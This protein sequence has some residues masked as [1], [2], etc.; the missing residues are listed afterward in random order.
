[1]SDRTEFT[2]MRSHD[3]RAQN[4]DP[5]RPRFHLAEVQDEAATA[6][7]GRPIFRTVERV[8]ILIPGGLNSPV[9][10]VTDNHRQRWP[11]AYQR[12]KQSNEVAIEGTPID[13]WAVLSRAQVAE[14]KALNVFTVEQCANLNDNVI[15]RIGMGGNAI[16]NA[17]KA[18]LDDA[19]HMKMVTHMT[20]ELDLRDSRITELETAIK[21]QNEVIGQLQA[22]MTM[23]NTEVP[24]MNIPAPV[25]V[26]PLAGMRQPNEATA[27]SLDNLAVRRRP[28]RPAKVEEP[29]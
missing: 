7:Q 5:I 17:A 12:F 10:N 19:E 2:F 14:L 16:R 20:R 26:D 4:H 9:Q 28:G 25:S 8:E 24:G 18:Y 11:E 23:R 29:V 27:S 13:Q 22:S 6:A 3:M 1:M 21:A 15:T